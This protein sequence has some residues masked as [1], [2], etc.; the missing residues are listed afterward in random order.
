MTIA[1]HERIVEALDRYLESI[2]ASDALP[3]PLRDVAER[4]STPPIT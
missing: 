1:D 3:L 2:K 4:R